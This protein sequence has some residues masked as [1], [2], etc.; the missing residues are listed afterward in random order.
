[1]RNINPFLLGLVCFILVGARSFAELGDTWRSTYPK[2]ETAAQTLNGI[3]WTGSH[4]VAVGNEGRVMTSFDGQSWSARP[5]PS[6]SSGLFDVWADGHVV[7]ACGSVG[8]VMRSRDGGNTWTRHPTGSDY[9]LLGVASAGTTVVTVG[10][11]G[12]VFVSHDE[13]E[14]WV[15]KDFTTTSL[16]DVLWTGSEMVAVGMNGKIFRSADGGDT[17][18]QAQVVPPTTPE[19]SSVASAPSGVLVAAGQRGG[20]VWLS[21]D[22]GATW[23]ENDA[24][25]L[26]NVTINSIVAV[27]DGLVAFSDSFFVY[28]TPALDSPWSVV[29]RGA[30]NV[31]Y[32]AVAVGGKAYAVGAGDLILEYDTLSGKM[33]NQSAWTTDTLRSAVFSRGKLWVAGG[34]SLLVS[35]DGGEHWNHRA[36]DDVYFFTIAPTPDGLIATSGTSVSVSHDEGETWES[37]QVSDQNF[38]QSAVVAGNT[39]LA[40]G[41]FGQIFRSTDQGLTWT[42]YQHPTNMIFRGMAVHGSRIVAVGTL[43]VI[44][45]SDDAGATWTTRSSS[46]SSN[47]LCV[48]ASSATHW[49]AGAEN[50]AIL[51]STDGGTSWSKV[52]NP[53]QGNITGFCRTATNLVAS[54]RNT[55]TPT[56][57]YENKALVSDLSGEFWT[58]VP[59]GTKVLPNCVVSDGYKVFMMG[60][61]AAL[62]EAPSSGSPWTSTA[63]TGSFTLRDVVWT[64][65]YLIAVGD[66]GVILKSEDHGSTWIPCVSGTTQNLVAITWTGSSLISVSRGQPATVFR[67]KD[68]GATWQQLSGSFP[69]WGEDVVSGNGLVIMGTGSDVRISLNDGDTWTKPSNAAVPGVFDHFERLGG[70]FYGI[71]SG[72]PESLY[73]SATGTSSWQLVAS[74]FPY[75][76]MTAMDGILFAT[77]GTATIGRSSDGGVTWQATPASVRDVGLSCLAWT[78]R[79][80]VALGKNGGTIFISGESSPADYLSWSASAGLRGVAARP[81]SPALVGDLPNLMAY[82]WDVDSDGR[83]SPAERGLMPSLSSGSSSDLLSLAFTLPEAPRVDLVLKLERTNNLGRWTTISEKRGDA[84]WQ[85]DLIPMGDSSSLPLQRFTIEVDSTEASHS[86]YRMAVEPR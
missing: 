10:S 49:F 47:L 29:S 86:F 35:S 38:L 27:G 69:L 18:A 5:A 57:S 30:V 16:N 19:L 71:D 11:D 14:T 70:Y 46:A 26:G 60:D 55:N 1:M 67:S 61:Q 2:R 80:L 59:T 82:A 74:P 42:F 37:H 65:S 33:T 34:R 9:Y 63:K 68:H 78:G 12:A 6:G 23:R 66:G 13:G 50:G 77:N 8:L 72:S 36:K 44:V 73:R 20:L 31:I 25:S 53:V 52:S 54:V 24:P 58:A 79:H 21:Q 41:Q 3:A 85:G 45:T 56:G 28:Y 48:F 81:E 84:P 76:S 22:G 51:R 40:A 4:L 83:L 43:D 75:R 64:G 62:L 39:W 32:G 17:W 15:R 7:Y